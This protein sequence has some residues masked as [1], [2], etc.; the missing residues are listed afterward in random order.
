MKIKPEQLSAHLKRGLAPM[1]VVFGDE[2]LQA[3][4]SC[5][6][7]RAAARAQGYAERDILHAGA[8]FDWNSLTRAT[9]TLSLFAE[10]RVTELR[11]P[12]GKP[13]EAG[14]AA[15]LEFTAH[16]PPDT[17]LLVICPKLDA[18]TQKAKWFAALE[19]AG[20]AVQVWPV[21]AAQLPAWIAQRCAARGL[22]VS[23]EAAT[24]LAQRVEGNLL[25]AAQDIEKLYLV[26]GA[27]KVDARRVTQAVADSARFDVY[28]LADAALAGDAARAARILRGL[29]AEQIEST[30]V[31]WAVTREVRALAGMAF[32]CR[33]GVDVEQ[34]LVRH[35]VWEKRKPLIKQA[36]RRAAPDHWQRLLLTAARID[37]VIKGLETGNVWDELLQLSLGIAGVE[38]AAEPSKVAL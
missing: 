27:V 31:L 17:L 5:D 30:L 19:Q 23:A 36:L 6:A 18:A 1:Y 26:H 21:S 28:D 37:R 14:A 35:K 20:V 15:L 9:Q 13:G 10:R 7:I 16:A 34:A 33:C 3:Q 11:L 22:Q 25:A 38:L 12:T 32:D 29:Q 24:L 2:P 8:G 4:E